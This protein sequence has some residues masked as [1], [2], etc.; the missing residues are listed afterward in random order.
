MS[1]QISL[2]SLLSF[3]DEAT[4]IIAQASSYEDFKDQLSTITVP[5]ELKSF[6]FINHNNL[7]PPSQLALCYNI[8]WGY[9]SDTV[10]IEE[11]TNPLL[12]SAFF[13]WQSKLLSI[14]LFYGIWR[15]GYLI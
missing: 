14:D 4:K 7:E 2:K 1:E 15:K 9:S 3:F 5:E 6:Y 12:L 10:D 8:V 13:L 11:L